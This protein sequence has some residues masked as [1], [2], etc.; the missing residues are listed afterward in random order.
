MST[1]LIIGGTGFLGRTLRHE[2]R[3]AGYELV[4][5]GLGPCL[6]LPIVTTT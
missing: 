2:A 1:A 3:D 6:P 4:V 5:F